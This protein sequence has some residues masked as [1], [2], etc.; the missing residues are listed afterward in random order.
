[1]QIEK[2]KLLDHISGEAVIDGFGTTPGMKPTT[3]SER[4]YNKLVSILQTKSQKNARKQQILNHIHSLLEKLGTKA[5]T[6]VYHSFDEPFT[7]QPSDISLQT[8][9][10]FRPE[11]LTKSSSPFINFAKLLF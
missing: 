5:R 7:L 3:N 9:Y 2:G 1:V 4:K 10:I 6:T 11:P 8:S